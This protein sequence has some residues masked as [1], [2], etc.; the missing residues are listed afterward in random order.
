MQGSRYFESFDL[1][2]ENGFKTKEKAEELIRWLREGTEEGKPLKCQ[3]A[4]IEKKKEKKNPRFYL[5]WR[6][7]RT[8]APSALRSGRMRP[9]GLFRRCTKRNW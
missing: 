2:K 6:N 1:Y 7:F 5:I 4:T 8:S 3:I 9:F